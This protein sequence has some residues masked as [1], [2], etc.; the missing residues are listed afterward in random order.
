MSG[1]LCGK[2]VNQIILRLAGILL[3]TAAIS[4]IIY[5]L[6]PYPMGALPV[7][8]GGILGTG[9]VMCL[10]TNFSLLGSVIIV[11]SSLIVGSILLAD[12]LVIV[13]LH[14]L[15]AFFA[16]MF[17]MFAPAWYAARQQSKAVASIWQKLNARKPEPTVAELM[18]QEA[19]LAEEEVD[20]MEDEAEP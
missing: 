1:V 16:R 7:G 12:T 6:R 3:T 5:M 11:I 17:G 13:C 14:V 9:T 10:K 2:E 4:S 20:E 15:G 18:A 19:E 8:S